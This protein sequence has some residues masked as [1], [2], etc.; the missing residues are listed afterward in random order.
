MGYGEK[1]AGI[2]LSVRTEK[3]TGSFHGQQG[4]LRKR[5]LIKSVKESR[6]SR[7]KEGILEGGKKKDPHRDPLYMPVTG[8]P[9][10]PQ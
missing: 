7:G 10:T 2:A 8:S 5:E 3:E 6:K 4:R 9:P 1:R